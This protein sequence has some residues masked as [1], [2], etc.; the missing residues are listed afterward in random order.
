METTFCNRINQIVI[1]SKS[2]NK[3]KRKSYKVQK[4]LQCDFY[5]SLISLKQV[6]LTRAYT[7]E[8]GLKA[9]LQRLVW[10]RCLGLAEKGFCRIQLSIY[11]HISSSEV[12]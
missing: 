10:I 8:L 5:L 9:L 3:F 12:A 2:E 11:G 6:V 1:N 7:S 4:K